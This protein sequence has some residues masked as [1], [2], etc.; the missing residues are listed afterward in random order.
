MPFHHEVEIEKEN[1]TYFLDYYKDDEPKGYPNDVFPRDWEGE[2]EDY[3]LE[4]YPGFRAN[5]LPPETTE[6]DK[7][8]FMDE[9]EATT[10]KKWGGGQGIGELKEVAIIPPSDWEENPLWEKAL[11]FFLM[12]KGAPNAEPLKRHMRKYKDILE[13]E[14]VKVHEFDMVKWGAYGPMRKLFMG[15]EVLVTREGAIL[16]RFSHGPWKR[17]LEVGFQ[18]FLASIDCPIIHQVHG[19]GI[20]E[21]GPWVQIAENKLVGHI[22]QAGNQDGVDQLLPV[23]AR[24]GFEEVHFA[25]L[26]FIQN[27]FE[28]SGEF[29]TDMVLGVPDIEIALIYPKC[30]DYETK[31]Y[32][33]ERNFKLIEVPEDEFHE[34]IPT[35]FVTLEPGKIIM[36]EGADETRRKLEEEGVE[37][38]P[39]DISEIKKGGTNG[40]RCTTLHLVREEG[41]HI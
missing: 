40:I 41:P 12:R 15:E 27:T 22:C 19:Y 18:R 10:G 1:N 14:G 13:E 34:Y 2:V 29:H 38:I 17:G 4:M 23:L 32:L 9:V 8:C 25:T 20:Q 5:D 30:L 3:P 31:R 21:P 36:A 6:L 16:P 37:V 28:A 33:K 26:P 24:S 35:N 11:D 7:Y 39:L